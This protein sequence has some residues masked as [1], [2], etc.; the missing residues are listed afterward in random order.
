MSTPA[1]IPRA[2]LISIEDLVDKC[3]MIKPGME[4]LIFAHREGLYG[5]VNL[6]DE[7]A[8]SWTASVVTS[9]GAN[10]SILWLDEPNE[11]H[12]WRYPPVLKGAAQ[13][14]DV[15]LNFSSTIT[16]EEISEFR[17]AMRDYDTWNVRVF[18]LT[19]PLLMTKWAQTPYELV[20]MIRHVSS[21]PFMK[22]EVQDFLMTDPNGTHLEGKIVTPVKREGIPGVPYGK[23]RRE[24]GRYT[25]WPEW[26]H[27][28]VRC[29]DVNGVF[30]FNRMLGWWAIHIGI[31]PE[32]ETPVSI[33]VEDG[34]M[35]AIN[36]GFEARAIKRFIEE[37]E[38]KVGEKIWYF[39]TFH[40]GVHPNARVQ[41]WQCPHE[42]HRRLIN[43]SHSSNLHWH[44]GSAPA[45][46]EYPYWPHITGD[47]R[48]ATLT[49]GDQLVYDN[50]YLCALDDPEVKEVEA[51]YPGRPGVPSREDMQKELY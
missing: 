32:W 49:V 23:W 10:C 40:F 42:L 34:K 26:L 30:N 17:Q 8:V 27:T 39:D 19:A 24:T 22:A 44:L 36:G 29:K 47:I 2:A 28:Q 15:L 43:H 37:L 41:S 18:A 5:G 46:E 35:T 14:A 13:N 4:V 3:A 31:K 11:T 7:D 1:G 51:R 9:R 12:A 20:S 6:V 21:K 45:N 25:P 50:G 33:T 48:Q 16:N 38:P